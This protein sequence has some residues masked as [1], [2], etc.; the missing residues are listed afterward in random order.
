[1]SSVPD[2][3]PKLP[4]AHSLGNT[5]PLKPVV[6]DQIRHRITFL[7]HHHVTPPRWGAI[8]PRN[9]NGHT[10]TAPKQNLKTGR[11]LGQYF[12]FCMP[13]YHHHCPQRYHPLGPPPRLAER[14]PEVR[15]LLAAREEVAPTPRTPRTP[16][17]IWSSPSISPTRRGTQTLHG[18]HQSITPMA[19][20]AGPSSLP[21]IQPILPRLEFG[22]ASPMASS[23]LSLNYQYTP[24]TVPG[25]ADEMAENNVADNIVNSAPPSPPANTI[26]EHYSREGTILSTVSAHNKVLALT[27]VKQGVKRFDPQGLAARASRC[28]GRVGRHCG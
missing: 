27:G 15:I 19:A 11:F 23:V 2:T 3:P 22:P 26:T 7:A 13:N 1:M 21:L 6:Q 28:H 24:A 16:R 14:V 4:V 9:Y 20:L 12:Q 10:F 8:L 18:S 17:R 25:S 5:S